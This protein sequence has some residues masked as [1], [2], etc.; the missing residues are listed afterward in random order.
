MV[1]DKSDVR[2]YIASLTMEEIATLIE[3]II[4][5]LKRRRGVYTE[6][7]AFLSLAEHSIKKET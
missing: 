7:E 4:S 1:L 3:D 6:T 5:S 2:K